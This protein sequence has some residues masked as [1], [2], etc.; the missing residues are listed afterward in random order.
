M[1]EPG[2][3]PISTELPKFGTD[4]CCVQTRGWLRVA[5]VLAPPSVS[6]LTVVLPL[7]GVTAG[8]L[9]SNWWRNGRRIRGVGSGESSCK[10]P[11]VNARECDVWPGAFEASE[12]ERS[13]QGLITNRLTN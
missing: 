10:L 4:I 12:P 5:A 6:F 11:R 3:W 9:H 8:N 7:A 1:P 13:K 2:L